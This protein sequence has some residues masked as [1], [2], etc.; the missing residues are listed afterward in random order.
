MKPALKLRTSQQLNLTPQIQQTIRMLQLGAKE[1]SEEIDETLSNNPLL[2]ESR[3]YQHS[4]VQTDDNSSWLE[5]QPTVEK[6]TLEDH[7]IKQLS[8]L[9]LGSHQYVMACIVIACLDDDGYLRK[10]ESELIQACANENITTDD[11]QVVKAINV[12]QQLE[13]VGVGCRDLAECLRL[14]V[15]QRQV[16]K[17][18]QTIAV[19]ICEKLE[20]LSTN[21]NQLQHLINVNDDDFQTTLDLIAQLDPAP[22]KAFDQETT[23]YI[24]PDVLL[25][26]IDNQFLI[27]LNPIINRGIEL[28]QHYIDLLKSSNKAGD[29]DYLK[30]N[31]DKAKWW[32]NALVQRNKT[33]YAVAEYMIQ[34]QSGYFERGDTM[35]LKP[36]KQQQIADTLDIHIST[37]SRAIR[38]KYVQTPIGLIALKQLLAGT[39]KTEDEKTLSNQA[40]KSIIKNLIKNEPSQT[41]LS[42]SKIVTELQTRGIIIARRTVNKYREQL[43]IPASNRRKVINT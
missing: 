32:L 23:I 28:N 25:T 8:F 37:V 20:L 16:D 7:L 15:Q 34:H 11:Q 4:S 39:V 36:L 3:T 21:K 2:Q 19:K 30:K 43:N 22:G 29:K 9:N 26:Q 6:Q 5:N 12:V 14:Q 1:L 13:P 18:I 41:P 38:D 27:Q 24:Q 31:L 35:A 10:S 33:L 17:K 40:V 42:D